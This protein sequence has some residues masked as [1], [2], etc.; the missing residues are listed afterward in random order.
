MR[1]TNMLDTLS[2]HHFMEDLTAAH[3]NE[4][5]TASQLY[6]DKRL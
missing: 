1:L 2:Q 6:Q 4:T 3:T 5:R